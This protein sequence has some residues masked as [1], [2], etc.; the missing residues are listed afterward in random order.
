MVYSLQ[1][2][3]VENQKRNKVVVQTSSVSITGNLFEV[4]T[5]RPYRRS[6]V[7]RGAVISVLT[8]HPGTLM[9]ADVGRTTLLAHPP[10]AVISSVSIHP[11]LLLN[12][13]FSPDFIAFWD[14]VF[15][16][17]AI[18]VTLL[19]NIFVMFSFF[20]CDLFN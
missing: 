1:F 15:L 3:L 7:G 18:T 10:Q 14:L 16:I 5:F 11:A 9:H 8:R 6:T 17:Q 2:S 4:Q 12:Y 19:E 13:P 20:V